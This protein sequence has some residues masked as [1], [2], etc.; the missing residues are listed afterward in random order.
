[1]FAL[2]S[3][4]QLAVVG[5]F[6]RIGN[7]FYAEYVRWPVPPPRGSWLS[8]SPAARSQ[9]RKPSGSA[10]TASWG[11]AGRAG[12]EKCSAVAPPEQSQPPLR[13]GRPAASELAGRAPGSD[14]E[15]EPG[16]DTEREPG[17]NEEPF[18]AASAGNEVTS[19]D[20]SRLPR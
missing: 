7:D 10:E 5:D 6:L 19:A 18:R 12:F 15:R 2:F 1:M 14:P 20:Q 8:R 17:R 3:D 4:E 9:T 13:P 16:R 11:T